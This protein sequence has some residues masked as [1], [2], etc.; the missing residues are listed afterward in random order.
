MTRDEIMDRTGA[1][2]WDWVEK[3]FSGRTADEIHAELDEMFPEDDN[4]ALA[5]EIYHPL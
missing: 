3:A 5:G 1:D 4:A 2:E